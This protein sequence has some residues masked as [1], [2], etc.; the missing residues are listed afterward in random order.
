MKRTYTTGRYLDLVDR[1]RSALPGLC[2]STDV[3]VGFPG[4]EDSD[5]ESTMALMRHI[6]YDSAFMFK[7]S[8]RKG[9]V[10]YREI[11][12]T[13]PEA[14]ESTEAPGRN[15]AAVENLRRDQPALYRT[16][17]GGTR[18]RATRGAAKGQAGRKIRL[19][20]RTV[21]FPKRRGQDPYTFVDI[22]ITDTTSHTLIG[23]SGMLK[24]SRDP[25]SDFLPASHHDAANRK[26]ES[27]KEIAVCRTGS[28]YLRPATQGYL[29]LKRLMR[30]LDLHTVCDRRQVSEYRRMLGRRYGYVHDSGGHLYSAVAGFAP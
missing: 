20:S 22:R 29:E 14:G 8:P 5:F 7:Y 19:D 25:V 15:R 13:V 10:A 30:E 9:T 26:P 21:V 6:R 27:E 1:L 18:P 17:A 24:R 2:L 3:I 16:T 12:D 4:E 23:R 11:P 28:G